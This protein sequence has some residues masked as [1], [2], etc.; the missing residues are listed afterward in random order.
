MARLTLNRDFT[1]FLEDE[2]FPHSV[3]V[4]IGKDVFT[5]SGMVLAQQ[6]TVIESHFRHLQGIFKLEDMKN[7][8]TDA[9]KLEC[10]KF[11]YG[12]PVAFSFQNIDTVIKF[13]SIYEVMDL[14]HKSVQWIQNNISERNICSINST[15]ST[16]QKEEHKKKVKKV[17]NSFITKSSD[18]VAVELFERLSH[19][20]DVDQ[21]LF[22]SV[23]KENPANGGNLL[24]EWTYKNAENKCFVLQNSNELDF[25]EL[26]PS[27]DNFTAFVT[28]LSADSSSID[29]MKQVLAL[30]QTYFVKS[31]SRV[32]QR[33]TTPISEQDNQGNEELQY[34]EQSDEQQQIEGEEEEEEE[35]DAEEQDDLYADDT[36]SVASSVNTTNS[37]RKSRTRGGRGKAKRTETW[38]AQN[39]TQGRRVQGKMQGQKNSDQQKANSGNVQKSVPFKAQKQKT[40]PPPKQGT[41]KVSPCPPKNLGKMP[42]QPPKQGTVPCLQKQTL[43]MVAKR[44]VFV[45]SVPSTATASD[46]MAPFLF[47]GPIVNV[48][49][50]SHKNIAFVEFVN[51]Q[52]VAT[53]LT[54]AKGGV[55]FTVLGQAVNVYQYTPNKS[56]KPPHNKSSVV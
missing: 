6:S 27:Q 44:K 9:Q 48:D 19:G 30:Q 7:I 15:C 21:D 34:V 11:M 38:K 14:F 13:A 24:E 12:S 52:S 1:R 51:E 55:K 31:A 5:C 10:I 37:S 54:A 41:V 45:S 25:V 56:S 18:K 35:E 53:V 2:T 22:L 16:L 33:Q 49:V 50:H 17:V 23:I 43:G 47:C 4:H 28:K 40:C 46:I 26:F 42:H 36:S 20:D 29:V 8:G 39:N 32:A 3:E